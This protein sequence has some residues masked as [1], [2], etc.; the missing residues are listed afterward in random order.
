MTR[1]HELIVYRNFENGQILEDM[2]W[3]FDHAGSEYYNEEDLRGLYYECIHGLVDL[4]GTYGFEGNL[5]HTYLTYLLVNNENAFSTA[6]EIRGEIS[7]SINELAYHDFEIFKE[8]YDFDFVAVEKALETSC[9]AMIA[10]YKGSDDQGKM[11]NK[12]IRDR[13]CEL[14]RR[15]GSTE[16]I[17]EFKKDMSEFYKDFGVGKL[18]L[19]KAF[20]VAHDEDGVHIVPITEDRP[21]TLERSR[22]LRGGQEKAH[23]QYRGLRGGPA[24]QQLPPF[25]RCGN[26]KIH[27][28]QSDSE[29]VL[30][31]RTSND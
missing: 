20:R 1:I 30:Q 8:L 4:A 26:R 10:D 9:Y 2:A 21:C 12:R 13:I 3:I 28:Y 22:G 11:F 27:E 19:H 23:R 5:W 25:W 18:G 16:S 31:P 17:D 24:G 15:L 6:S 29:S 14:S 7:G